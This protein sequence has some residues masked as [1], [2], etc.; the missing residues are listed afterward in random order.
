V[1]NVVKKLLNIISRVKDNSYDVGKAT[2]KK[3]ILS[4]REITYNAVVEIS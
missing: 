2:L 4:R 1:V 3:T